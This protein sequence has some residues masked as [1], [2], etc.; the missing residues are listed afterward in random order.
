MRQIKCVIETPT[1]NFV[2]RRGSIILGEMCY[3]THL[4]RTGLAAIMASEAGRVVR[5][6]LMVLSSPMLPLPL[7]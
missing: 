1:K 4:L 2:I 6:S 5:S 7:G 3:M